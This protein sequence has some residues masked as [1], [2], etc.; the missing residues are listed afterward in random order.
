M[1]SFV[2]PFK[3]AI[4]LDLGLKRSAGETC[5]IAL[6]LDLVSS[7]NKKLFEKYEKNIFDTII[8]KKISLTHFSDGR[9][10]KLQWLR[11]QTEMIEP[12]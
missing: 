11:S 3:I 8:I 4:R 2:V 5:S 1:I 9:R 10:I 12:R 7:N 6:R